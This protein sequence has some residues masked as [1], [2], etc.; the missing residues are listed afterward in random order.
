[1]GVGD[2]LWLGSKARMAHSMCG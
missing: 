1:M 2:A